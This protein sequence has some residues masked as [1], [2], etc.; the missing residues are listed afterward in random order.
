METH[1][2]GKNHEKRGKEKS[3]SNSTEAQE[4]GDSQESAQSGET[5]AKIMKSAMKTQDHSVPK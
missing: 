3:R 2:G 5:E 4:R 1:V